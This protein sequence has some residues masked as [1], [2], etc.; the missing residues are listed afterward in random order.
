MRADNTGG[1]SAYFAG[2]FTAAKSQSG[3]KSQSAS[4]RFKNLKLT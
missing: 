1:F 3:R 2:G 4:R